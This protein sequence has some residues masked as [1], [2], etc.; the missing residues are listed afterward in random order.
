M[1]VSEVDTQTLNRIDLLADRAMPMPAIAST[2]GLPVETV[3]TYLYGE[4]E[5]EEDDIS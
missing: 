3:E 4:Q 1:K 2:L 5:G